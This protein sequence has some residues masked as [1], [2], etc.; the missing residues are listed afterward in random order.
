MRN[1]ANPAR[2]AALDQQKAE[3]ETRLRAQFSS[4]DRARLS[5]S[6]ILQAYSKY[7]KRF[8]KTYHVQLQ[9]ESIIFKGKSIPNVAALVEAM[10]MAELK[11]MLLTAGHD[12]ATLQLPVTIDVSKGDERYIMINGQA[13][14]LK[15]GD[16]MMTDGGGI[17]SNVLYGPDQRTRITPSTA[18]AFFMVYIPPGIENQVVYQ[19]LHDIQ[20][21]VMTIAPQAHTEL[22]QVY[23]A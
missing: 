10:F 3:L 22:L 2:H 9:L 21:N 1:V 12:L 5:E 13:Q 4:Y 14:R 20:A 19:H 17:I 7:F 18:Q 6:S 15:P 11:N 8:K 23:R 16:M